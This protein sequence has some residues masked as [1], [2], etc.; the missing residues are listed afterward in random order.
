MH[1][2][3]AFDEDD[4]DD[5]AY[6]AVPWRVYV[7]ATGTQTFLCDQCRNS[8]ADAV[9]A[10]C[11]TLCTPAPTPPAA[12]P[13]D[14]MTGALAATASPVCRAR[15]VACQG[16][17]LRV[18]LSDRG[19]RFAMCALCAGNLLCEGATFSAAARARLAA[20]APAPGTALA[21]G[22][23]R[24]VRTPGDEALFPDE[25]CVAAVE[26]AAATL[27]CPELGTA[28]PQPPPPCH[29]RRL[30][31]FHFAGPR[32]G[33][34]AGRALIA[35]RTP[36][37][38]YGGEVVT[39]A[40]AAARVTRHGNNG[41]VMGLDGGALVCDAGAQPRCRTAYANDPR[42]SGL[43]PNCAYVELRCGGGCLARSTEGGDTCVHEH[44]HAVLLTL[45]DIAPGEE[46]LVRYGAA[47]W[48]GGGDGGNGGDGGEVHPDGGPIM[49]LCGEVG[50]L[51]RIFALLAVHDR[52]ACAAVQRSWRAVLADS[53]CW[54]SVFLGGE[55]A[56]PAVAAQP[57]RVL[58]ALE[59]AA[60]NADGMLDE[61]DLRPLGKHLIRC[62]PLR[63]A[64][65]RVQAVER[66]RAA[67]RVQAAERVPSLWGVIARV[68]RANTSLRRLA[69]TRGRTDDDAADGWRAVR[70]RT[71]HL[72]YKAFHLWTSDGDDGRG[73]FRHAPVGRL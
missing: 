29:V 33:L 3:P 52:A 47:Y 10:A 57:L 65:V 27:L 15:Q 9:H 66:V 64:D 51:R 30:P 24:L 31:R 25:A 37:L 13:C 68:A 45:R 28:L 40:E 61:L 17:A 60:A 49:Q 18:C 69:L 55:S 53:G 46:L 54:R 63:E 14:V 38:S 12:D 22:Q 34:Y 21:P 41:F 58:W 48:A 73:A 7:G 8:G 43:A 20:A 39:A 70:P 44:S 50:V 67:E 16:T 35:A 36:L 6:V 19:T 72:D 1:A 56:S 59:A 2:A 26:R 23:V 71:A 32:W 4:N 62:N 5:E 42:G 11:V